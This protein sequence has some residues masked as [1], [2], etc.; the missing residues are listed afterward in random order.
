MKNVLSPIS[1]TKITDMEA[2]K[3]CIKP[4]FSPGTAFVVPGTFSF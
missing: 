4:K 1:E 3:A 2:K